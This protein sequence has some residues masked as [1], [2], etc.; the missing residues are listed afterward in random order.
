MGQCLEGKNERDLHGLTV[1][2]WLGRAGDIFGPQLAS[3]T[4]TCAML[5]SILYLSSELRLGND[6]DH[7]IGMPHN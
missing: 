6:Q 7:E 1:P 4:A 2:K 5:T 3:G